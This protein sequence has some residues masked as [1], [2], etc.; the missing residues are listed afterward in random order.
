[1]VPTALPPVSFFCA[2]CPDML[3][4]RRPFRART[5]NHKRPRFNQ[6][7]GPR[8]SVAISSSSPRIAL[9]DFP[10]SAMVIDEHHLGFQV[11]S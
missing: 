10:S 7:L 1:M 2:P 11:L 9:T 3:T 5:C 4:S 8:L 6:V